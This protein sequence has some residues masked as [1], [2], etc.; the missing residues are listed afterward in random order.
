MMGKEPPVL[1]P[2]LPR[3]FSVQTRHMRA[4][5][6]EPMNYEPVHGTLEFLHHSHVVKVD[7]RSG[8]NAD[9]DTSTP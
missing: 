5:Q 6:M 8:R 3:Q 4:L 2:S 7:L 9:E 1:V